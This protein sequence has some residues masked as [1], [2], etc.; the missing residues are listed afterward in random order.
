MFGSDGLPAVLLWLHVDDILIHAPTLSKLEAALEHIL[1]VTVRLGLICHCSKTDPPSQKVKFCGFEYDTSSTPT[2]CTPPNKVSRAT[3]ITEYLLTGLP[4]SMSRLVV[5]MVVGF[6]QSLVPATPGNIGATFLRP[7]YEDLHLLSATTGPQTKE[8]YFQHMHLSE[9]SRMCLEWWIEALSLGLQRIAQPTDVA[10]LGISWGDGSG[11]GAGGTFNLATNETTVDVVELDV[12]RGVWSLPVLNFSSNWKE[13]RTLLTTLENEQKNHL[14]RVTNR[15]LIYLT[16]NMVTYDVFRRGTSKSTPLWNLF[17]RI[18]LLELQL[19]CHLQVIHVPGTIMIKQGTDGLSRGVAMQPLA[20]HPSNSLIP[21]LWRAAPASTTILNWAQNK[22]CFNF[23]T[24]NTWIMQSD[25]S[26]WS[27]SLMI[28]HPV[29]WC[30]SP[31][32]ARQAILQALSSWVES[33]TTSCHIFLVPRILQRDFGRLSKFV[34]FCGQYIDLPLPFTPLVPFVLYFLP[35]F[36]RISAY[37]Q[38]L[39]QQPMDKTTNHLPSW[40]KTEIDGLLRVSA[41]S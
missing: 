6:L 24:S 20:S 23:P 26:N 18:K 13:L 35:P 39:Q 36:N 8:S 33:P 2:L 41:P 9:R 31:S 11:T 17:L 34:I 5:S 30:I 12:W 10:T 32:F 14:G 7:V 21:L 27:R 4:S 38:Q 25:F 22:I 37:Q 40:I 19:Q 15:R 1:K 3:A 16:D 29:L 28:H